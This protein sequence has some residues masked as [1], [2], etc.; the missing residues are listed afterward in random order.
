LSRNRT[1]HTPPVADHATLNHAHSP[2]T[3]R[4]II[5]SWAA[6]CPR[7]KDDRHMMNNALE[8]HMKPS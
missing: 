6:S 7:V 5:A 8:G 2:L 3:I 1:R 4:S